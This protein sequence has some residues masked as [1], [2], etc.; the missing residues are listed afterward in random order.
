MTKIGCANQPKLICKAR[1]AASMSTG[2]LGFLG[3]NHSLFNIIATCPV[4]KNVLDFI[5]IA[6]YTYRKTQLITIS[7]SYICEILN[8]FS[9]SKV[10][11]HKHSCTDMGSPP[12]SVEITNQISLAEG[13]NSFFFNCH[14]ILPQ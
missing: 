1:S 8:I 10:S 3:S 2:L 5:Y 12:V 14:G 7:F 4:Y 9:T 11:D 13:I 6:I